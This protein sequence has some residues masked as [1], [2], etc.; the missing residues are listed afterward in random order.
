MEPI[1]RLIP[2]SKYVE[3]IVKGIGHCFEDIIN[4]AANENKYELRKLTFRSRYSLPMKDKLDLN[5]I[6]VNGIPILD[7]LVYSGLTEEEKSTVTW[8]TDESKKEFDETD[9][10]L[11]LFSV[12]FMMMT[13][14]KPI[15]EKDEIMPSFLT[16]IMKGRQMS[17]TRISEVLTNNNVSAFKHYWIRAVNINKLPDSVRNRFAKGISG[18]RVVSIFKDYVPEKLDEENKELYSN[19]EVIAKN[20]PYWEFHNLFMPDHLKNYSING[21]LGN[22]ILNVYSERQINKM[23]TSRAL[24]SYPK[25]NPRFEQY[26][27]WG[28]EFFGLFK[29][30]VVFD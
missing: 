10:G 12:Y 15:P 5:D 13:R 25:F 14:G 16:K 28:K 20:G 2:S 30:R 1:E 18:S 24:Y 6:I 4:V 11:S 23:V 8:V 17:A 3:L 21:N 19:L 22:F 29:D 7:Y 27:V 26:R 9:F